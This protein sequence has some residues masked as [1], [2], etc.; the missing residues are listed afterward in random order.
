MFQLSLFAEFGRLCNPFDYVLG[1]TFTCSSCS[2]ICGSGS[3]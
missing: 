2:S 1:F 3:G